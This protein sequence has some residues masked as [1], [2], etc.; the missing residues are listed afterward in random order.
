MNAVLE[1]GERASGK[2][3]TQEFKTYRT[4][5]T[6]Y[7]DLFVP[8]HASIPA[9][10]DKDEASFVFPFLYTFLQICTPLA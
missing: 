2:W 8:T 7:V 5:Q 10:N 4:S 9:R 6:H 3:K 1:P